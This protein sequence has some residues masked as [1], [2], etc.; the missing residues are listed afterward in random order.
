MSLA[1][2]DVLD[3]EMQAT[4]GI[5]LQWYDVLVHLEDAPGGLPMN[6]LARRILHSKS[7]LTRIVDRMHE[8]GLV[9]RERPEHDRRVVLVV[10]AGKG[11]E[12]IAQTRPHHRERIAAHFTSHL[13]PA[14]R[15]T[16]VAALTPV[17]DHIE[18]LRPGRISS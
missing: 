2:H 11:R 14:L 17:R 7:G 3:V 18:P 9:R 15:E 16:L 8:A 13:T 4:A 12:L 10:L 1:L 6:D 5:S